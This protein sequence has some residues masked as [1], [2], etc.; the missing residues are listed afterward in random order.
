MFHLEE[1][2]KSEKMLTSK[3]ESQP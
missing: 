1:L 3:L 2:L